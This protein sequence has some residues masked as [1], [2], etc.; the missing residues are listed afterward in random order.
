MCGDLSFAL[1]NL[2]KDRSRA[3]LTSFFDF[4]TVACFVCMAIAFFM[5]TERDIRTLLQLFVSGIAFAV[6]NQV[7]NAGWTIL[8]LI[9]VVAGVGYAGF[10]IKSSYSGA[11]R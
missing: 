6:A 8:A 3:E 1:K 10:V 9:L 11:P 7:G 2:I 5:L 4:L